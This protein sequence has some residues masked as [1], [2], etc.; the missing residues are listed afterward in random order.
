MKK[1]VNKILEL[2][3]FI[4]LHHFTT[5]AASIVLYLLLNGGTALFLT[6]LFLRAF[7][8]EEWIL[9]FIDQKYQGILSF[10]FQESGSYSFFFI[11]TGI[12]S[13]TNLFFQIMQIGEII[14]Q[15]KKHSSLFKRTISLLFI[16]SFLVLIIFSLFFF[17]VMERFLIA[18]GLTFLNVLFKVLLNISIPLCLIFFLN[19][20][21][22]PRLMDFKEIMW[23]SLFTYC[24]WMFVGFFYGIYAANSKYH[25]IYGAL[26][27]LMIFILYLY[28]Q[29][30]GLILGFLINYKILD[31]K[32]L[33]EVEHTNGG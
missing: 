23:G 17:F 10:L 21:V 14:Y 2:I 5:L 19:Y 18:F 6:L 4:S 3:R 11:I 8:L 16:V 20:L 1:F 29:V 22:P 24:Y 13:A 31:C 9:S 32:K 25:H 7:R 33:N 12:Y 26:S 27:S 30:N 28:I 15:K